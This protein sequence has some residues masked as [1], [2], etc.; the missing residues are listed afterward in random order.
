MRMANT[1]RAQGSLG[2]CCGWHQAFLGGLLLASGLC[3]GPVH[4]VKATVPATVAVNIKDRDR[5]LNDLKLSPYWKVEAIGKGQFMARARTVAAGDPFGDSDGQFLFSLMAKGEAAK[6]PDG[7]QLSNGS[8]TSYKGRSRLS[9]SV[10]V[11]LPSDKGLTMAKPGEE[12]SLPVQGVISRE[13]DA[14]SASVLG[15][16]IS[17]K[18]SIHMILTEQG[19]DPDRKA[20]LAAIPLVMRELVGVQALP[21]EYRTTEQY[22]AF[23]RLMF[24]DTSRK[25]GIGRYPG[26]QSR[27]TFYGYLHARTGVSYEGVSLKVSHPVYCPVEGTGKRSR[28]RKAEYL[29]RPHAA[30]E[31]LFF[32]IEDNAV[33]L[34]GEHDQRFGIFTGK[35]SFEGNLVLLNDTGAILL[36]AR[37]QFKGWQR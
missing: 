22:A 31:L 29:G 27:D 19:S 28:L 15:I 12:V 17:S 7:N 1:S 33:Y 10:V 21:A 37:Q 25:T 8:C 23:Y 20:T 11:G 24:A 4:T 36:V 32:L 18:H 30:G 2:H 35:E 14:N 9:A 3:A 34:A 16:R 13:L 5:F 6:L 26:S